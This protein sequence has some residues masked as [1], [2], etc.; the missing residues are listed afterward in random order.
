[1]QIITDF[2]RFPL[3]WRA[4]NGQ[5]GS[6]VRVATRDEFVM[7]AEVPDAVLLVN[8]RVDIALALGFR[9]LISR[10]IRRSRAPVV[11]VDLVLRKPNSRVRQLAARGKG[12][13][14]RELDLI[15]NYFRDSSRLA[16]AFHLD[17]ARCEYT[18]F[19]SNLWERRSAVAK[20]D[21]DY[22]L[23]F[24][25]SL[26]DFDTFIE[27]VRL[28]GVPAAMPR[29]VLSA[30]QAHGSRLSW[31]ERSL[32]PNLTFLDD[33]QSETAEARMLEHARLV[34]VPIL[35]E[36]LVA[37]GIGTMMNAMALG[38]CTIASECVG[39][40]DIFSNQ[41]LSVPPSSPTALAALLRTAWNDYDLR[42]RTAAAGLG[43]AI[44][45]GGE[46]DLYQRVIDLVCRRF[47]GR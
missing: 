39:V 40:S 41:V 7:R 1:M 25:R 22:V 12:A 42:L 19:K 36:S 37:S 18:P 4:S 31:N 28:S 34:V 5:M 46:A 8:G 9:C 10:T 32:P 35:P 44:E 43:F 20:P 45:C 21:G 27:A 29:P 11:A 33:D 16:T 47:V 2:E 6:S 26:R 23:C 14:L 30:L 24:G 17:P 38:K 3:E 13:M 15:V